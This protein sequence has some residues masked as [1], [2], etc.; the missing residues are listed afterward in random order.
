MAAIS[1]GAARTRCAAGIGCSRQQ[2]PTERHAE[3]RAGDAG[4]RGARRCRCRARRDRARATPTRT[5]RRPRTASGTRSGR[6]GGARAAGRPGARRTAPKIA[7]EAPPET[8]RSPCATSDTRLPARPLASVEQQQARRAE[9]T[10]DRRPQSQSAHMFIGQM[11]EAEV[12]EH[13][14]A[15]APPFPVLGGRPEVRAPV[16][17]HLAG[18]MPEPGTETQHHEEDDDVEGDETRGRGRSPR[19]AAHH[20]GQARWAPHPA[21][22]DRASAAG[23]SAAARQFSLRA[24]RAG[25][26]P[27]AGR[28][29]RRDQGTRQGPGKAWLRGGRRC[30]I[31]G[32]IASWFRGAVAI[33]G[34]PGRPGPRQAGYRPPGCGMAAARPLA[35]TRADAADS[36]WRAV[37]VAR[38]VRSAHFAAGRRRLRALAPLDGCRWISS[39]SSGATALPGRA[40]PR[41]GRDMPQESPAAAGPALRAL[42]NRPSCPSAARQWLKA[43][44]GRAAAPGAV[45]RLPARGQP[46]R[47]V[48][49]R[50]RDWSARS[51][52]NCSSTA[53]AGARAF[54][55][56]WRPNCCA[57]MP[58]AS[59]ALPRRASPHAE[60]GGGLRPRAWMPA[61]RARLA[62]RLL[63][64]QRLV[65]LRHALAAGERADLELADAPADREMD[66]GGV[67]GL[68]RTRRDDAGEAA[69]PA[70][71]PRQRSVSR[72]RAALV[73]L[74]QHG[75]GRADAPRPRAPARASRDQEVVAD[76]LHAVAGGAGEAREALRRR[77]RPAGPR[78]RRSGSGRASAAAA[79]SCR[80]CRARAPPAPSV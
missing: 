31:R 21:A 52:T 67:L 23:P 75:V 41:C 55:R 53:G 34:L 37:P 10:L 29:V 19:A 43:I 24:D 1:T 47:P 68:A 9:E 79:R 80:R 76:D 62:E 57:C 26:A 46:D 51:S 38:G 27:S 22:A 40:S 73:G 70:R 58:G 69:R 59:A 44:P 39:P 11:D 71:R 54:R 16:E 45:P 66:D 63:D 4:R 33:Y 7:P 49:G 8:A 35:D 12:Q 2:R 5:R 14:A 48:L 77:P 15:E 32:S 17:L 56:R 61:K 28:S 64:P 6:P 65:P 3:Q 72:Q 78:S 30:V 13:R 25:A 36:R 42:P 60:R 20:V 18:R 50:C 74:E